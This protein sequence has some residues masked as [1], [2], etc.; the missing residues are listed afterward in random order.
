MP[1]PSTE[2]SKHPLRGFSSLILI[3][4]PGMAALTSA[5]TLEERVLNAPQ[6]LH[7]SIFTIASLEEEEDLLAF[8]LGAAVSAM[9]ALRFGAIDD[10]VGVWKRRRGFALFPTFALARSRVR[11]RTLLPRPV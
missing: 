9:V 2:I 8:A 6:D 4:A 3:F 5:S 7:A 11:L 1:L 10:L